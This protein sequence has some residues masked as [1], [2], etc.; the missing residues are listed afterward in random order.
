ML[1]DTPFPYS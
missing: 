1:Q